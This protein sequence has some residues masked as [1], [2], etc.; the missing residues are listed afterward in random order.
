MDEAL[1]MEN[2]QHNQSKAPEDMGIWDS[3]QVSEAQPTENPRTATEVEPVVEVQ[4]TKGNTF[5]IPTE[6]STKQHPPIEASSEVPSSSYE[7]MS[8]EQFEM[9]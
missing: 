3:E 1:Y 2:V 8:Y 7:N 5:K 6:T 4:G 9:A